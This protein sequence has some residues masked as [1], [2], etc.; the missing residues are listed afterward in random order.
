MKDNDDSVAIDEFVKFFNEKMGSMIEFTSDKMVASVKNSEGKILDTRQLKKF[1]DEIANNFNGNSNKDSK[2]YRLLYLYLI[3]YYMNVSQEEVERLLIHKGDGNNKQ[4]QIIEEQLKHA[5]AELAKKITELDSFVN[6]VANHTGKLEDIVNGTTNFKKSLSLNLDNVVNGSRVDHIAKQLDNA[7]AAVAAVAA[8]KLKEAEDAA[9]AVASGAKKL[10]EAEDA[11]ATAATA[12]AAA[13]A[14]A[15]KLK[16]AEDAA[17][18]DA[19]DAAK[20]LKAADAAAAAQKLKEAENAV[21]AVAAK[22][23]KEAED[24]AKKL[25]DAAAADAAAAAQKLKDAAATAAADAAAAAQKLKD[26]ATAAT[27]DAVAAAQK[28]KDAEDTAKKLKADAAAAAEQLK[29]ADAAAE[30]LRQQLSQKDTAAKVAAEQLQ[31]AQNELEKANDKLGR[32]QSTNINTEI[33]V[34]ILESFKSLTNTKSNN[35]QQSNK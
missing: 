3:K 25:K 27:A 10:K 24:V 21:D 17:A 14:A 11:A 18:A 31:T 28:L 19:A 12:A 2:Y 13:A 33:L 34:Q 5:E 4:L 22:K 35:A 6:V 1:M 26:A 32:Q 9:D 16:E 20:K 8:A 7:I 29:A 30:Q 15:K 23:L